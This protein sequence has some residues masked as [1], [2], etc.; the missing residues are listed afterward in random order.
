MGD[1]AARAV[2][3]FR[4]SRVLTVARGLVLLLPL[5]LLPAPAWSGIPASG[6][7]DICAPI[8]DPCIID[9]DYDVTGTLD[10]G[11]RSVEMVA[12]GK[13]SGHNVRVVC[14]EFLRSTSLGTTN[15]TIDANNSVT[16][17]VQRRCSGDDATPCLT[18]SVCATVSLGTCSLGSGVVSANISAAAREPGSG[19]DITV[20]AAGDIT[21]YGSLN[22]S[23]VGAAT[24]GGE[25]EVESFGGNVVVESQVRGNN[26]G[27]YYN[28]SA[29][30]NGSL[31]IEA[32]GDAAL[33]GDASMAGGEGDGE[34]TII[35]GGDI[36][37]ANDVNVNSGAH[38]FAVG[39]C[40]LLDA[41]GDINVV[42]PEGADPVS[43]TSDG[44]GIFYYGSWLSGYG[45]Y[46][47]LTAGGS[48]DIGEGTTLRSFGGPGDASGGEI[49]LDASGSVTVDGSILSESP[50]STSGDGA[51]GQITLSSPVGIDVGP[52][53]LL[54]TSGTF[55]GGGV[56][57][58]ANGP[59]DLQGDVD[60]RGRAGV[61]CSYGY[62]YP[63]G[64]GGYFQMY[65]TDITVG[66]H[67]NG[68]GKYASEE[69]NIDACRL[70]IQQGGK[71]LLTK[72]QPNDDNGRMNITVVESM[73]VENGG[74]IKADAAVSNPI[75]ITY[76]TDEKPPVFDGNVDP[77]ALLNTNPSLGGCSV[78]GNAEIDKDESCD[79]GNTTSG[80]GCRDDCQDEGCLAQSPGFPTTPL[81]DD[82]Q[83]CTVD[84]CNPVTHSCENVVSC[85]DGILCT[86]D[87]CQAG[88]CVHAPQD[89][90]CDD[91]NDCTDDMCNDVTGCVYANL[92]SGICN[93]GDPCTVGEI[94][95]SGTCTGP[96]VIRTER[97]KLSVKIRS[98]GA[99]DKL[100]WKGEVESAALNP[101]PTVTGMRVELVDSA[102][103]VV[104]S[105]DLPAAAFKMQGSS[106]TRFSGRARAGEFPGVEGAWKAKLKDVPNK[107]VIKLRIK[108]S[109]VAL[110]STSGEPRLTIGMLLGT[111]PAVDECTSALSLGCSG[112][113]SSSKCTDPDD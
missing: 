80:D 17:T 26:G 83:D 43:I 92:S 18:D 10:F 20:R 67:V 24:D 58:D 64:Y 96:P 112:S 32:A 74:A 106:G 6:A 79:D 98:G 99:D 76:R 53:A 63:R 77:P 14:G 5:V 35:A 44:G 103:A 88:T 54:S 45:G 37:I 85:S 7:D 62:C 69:W 8:D 94:C 34:L 102:R 86:D 87:S 31:T 11:T 12:G 57:I 42:R 13:L 101:A 95:N 93:D 16:L 65:G 84:R 22:V 71:L 50:I 111:D 38:Q 47:D 39:G 61:I 55:F 108:A 60:V 21:L 19:G 78:C 91:N 72:G 97:N 70:T 2:H 82:G 113:S 52:N 28:Y 107:G 23:G 3:V 89:L 36:T 33:L 109:D 100:S 66:G 56:R 104:I 29:G 25:V 4:A 40:V 105:E 90:L 15:R 81:C 73:H 49:L 59:I 68:G 46:H 30:L 110:D 48:I 41:G 1:M 75:R 9:Q 51:G 27:G